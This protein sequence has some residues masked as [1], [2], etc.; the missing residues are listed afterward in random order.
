M[1]QTEQTDENEASPEELRQAIELLTEMDLYRLRK[2]AGYLLYGS[3]YQNPGE[4]LNEAMLRAI[5][6]AAGGPGR[7]WKK[8]VNFMAFL[9]MCMRGIS[10][11]SAESI[12]QTRTTHTEDLATETLAGDDA[13][14]A[15]GHSHPDTV[16]LAL[17]SEEVSLRQAVAK[18]DADAIDLHFAGD[19]K[20]L[21]IIMGYKDELT[22]DEIRTM[23][24]MSAT[25]YD[26]AKRRFRRG[27]DK[28]FPGRRAK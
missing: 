12:V 20:V 3:E 5:S 13:L 26:T 18:A 19:D 1:E 14:S 11:D 24:G 6:A 16:E 25:E 2:T 17:Q 21:W 8:K 4:L 15:Y 7:I 10:N 22:A 27:L 9:I 28:I 23:S